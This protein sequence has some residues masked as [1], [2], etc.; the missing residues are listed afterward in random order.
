MLEEDDRQIIDFGDTPETLKGEYLDV[1][2]R[3]RSEIL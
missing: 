3:V 2:E 1:Y